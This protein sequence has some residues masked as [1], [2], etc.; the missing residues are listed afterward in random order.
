MTLYKKTS[1]TRLL[2]GV[3]SEYS[4]VMIIPSMNEIYMALK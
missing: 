1:H 4:I 3:T 2:W